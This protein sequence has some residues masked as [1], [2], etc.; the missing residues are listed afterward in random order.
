VLLLHDGDDTATA[1]VVHNLEQFVR[2]GADAEAWHHGQIQ[3]DIGDGAAEGATA[4]LTLEIL[5]CW[6]EEFRI[7]GARRVG[8][9]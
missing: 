9:A 2:E 5:Q 4:Y 8:P 7:V 6:H 1:E 3:A